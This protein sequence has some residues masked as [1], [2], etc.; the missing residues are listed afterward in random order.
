MARIAHAYR[1]PV[2]ET[3][4]T[5]VALIAAAYGLEEH[6]L[7]Q[8]SRGRGPRPPERTWEARKMALHLTVSVADCSYKRLADHIGFHKD[9]VTSACA[10]VRNEVLASDE[11]ETK[12]HALE[13]LVRRR[14]EGLAGERVSL[15]RA[16]L[17]VLEM[18]AAGVICPSSVAHP[19]IHPS[20]P[21]G[22]APGR[23]HERVITLAGARRRA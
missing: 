21:E 19:S 14:L 4:S 7:R 22:A 13:A 5:A 16:E 11:L 6:E 8:D 9:T 18:A 15:A 12:A 23:D 2:A 20:K 10:D 1:W 17:A 3:W